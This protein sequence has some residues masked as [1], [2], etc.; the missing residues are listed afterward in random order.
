MISEPKRLAAVVLVLVCVATLSA[1]AE[2]IT[3]GDVQPNDP[4]T[5]DAN[6]TA[7]VGNTGSGTL[8]ITNG[9]GV[10]TLLN[11]IGYETGSTGIA[12]VDGNG[13]LWV[14]SE[15]LHVGFRGNGT[16]DITNGGAV[17]SI[18]SILGRWSGS[19]GVAS[20]DGVGSTWTSSTFLSVG[21][22]SSGTLNITNG[23]A[24]SNRDGHIGFSVSDSIGLVTVDGAGSTWT[25]SEYLFV[26]WHGKA[27][28]NITNGGAVSSRN[29]IINSF[30][31]T[32]KVTVDGA[33]STWTNSKDIFVGK[34]G[35]GTLNI[36]NG[37]EVSNHWGYIGKSPGSSGVVTVDGAGST[38]N[39]EDIYISDGGSGTLNITNGGEVHTKH[40]D[41]GR[42]AGFAGVATVKGTGSIWTNSIGL[43]VGLWSSGTLNITD[44]G[45]VSSFRGWIGYGADSTGV[46][47]VDGDGSTWTNN[48][49]LHIGSNPYL[50]NAGKGTLKITNEGFVSVGVT[51]IIDKYG[52]VDSFINMTTGG[53]LALRDHAGLGANSL[54][55]F[56]E[57]VG[58]T[59]AIRYWDDSNSDWADITGATLG[60]DYTLEHISEGDL[61]GFTVLTVGVVPRPDPLAIEIDIRPGSDTNPVNLKSKGMLPVTIFGN[62]DID[63]SQIDLATLALGGAAPKAKGK[64]GKVGSFADVDGD[65]V[66]DLTLR[67]RI[68]DMAIAPDAEELILTGM[69]T[70]GAEFE[71][72]DS[73]RIV[74]HR[75][76]RRR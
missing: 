38:W 17:S 13:S 43:C 24:V 15:R 48:D 54:L 68:K 4:N 47:T 30:N 51:L 7:Y 74:R 8:N 62:D 33:G 72:R 65:S 55:D 11:N 49:S 19:T 42:K 34:Q 56:L 67:F 44:G 16:L 75:R 22:R 71:G 5:W 52:D 57:L 29:G 2:I 63:V 18:V 59:D 41:L 25:S 66:L 61:A 1:R 50:K 36:T 39:N 35:S 53:M 46:V 31:S 64:S 28:L 69:L 12:T 6:T 20:V 27:T 70:D 23:G 14:S 32:A 60:E 45:V 37:G 58:G 26:G 21:K 9:D 3:T 76:H 73:I 40:G 10:N